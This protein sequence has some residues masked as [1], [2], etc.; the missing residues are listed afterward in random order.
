[1]VAYSPWLSVTVKLMV[2]APR[3]KPSSKKLMLPS[4]LAPKVE[5]SPSRSDTH[6]KLK[7]VAESSRS[8]TVAENN[9]APP[10]SPTAPST[11]AKMTTPGTSPTVYIMVSEQPSPI[12][13]TTFIV[14]TWVPMVRVLS[15]NTTPP[16]EL[17][18]EVPK[19]PSK[20]DVQS[21]AKLSLLTSSSVAVPSKVTMAPSI[22]AL[23]GAG[24]VISQLGRLFAGPTLMTT[25]AK[26]VLP[27]W[28]STCSFRAC[29]PSESKLWPSTLPSASA[30]LSTSKRP[31]ISLSQDTISASGMS[32]A[33]E[34]R[35]ERL[36]L[37]SA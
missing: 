30:G 26:A 33:S 10:S 32:S 11:G 18:V 5:N 34:M 19:N 1:M 31:S 24:Y 8:T 23:T 35:P 17:G 14:M 20:L 6:D 22:L 37:V 4:L 27:V 29:S 28:S 15:G 16:S 13:S 2:W 3:D 36:T 12:S 7:S 9:T 21:T 25:E